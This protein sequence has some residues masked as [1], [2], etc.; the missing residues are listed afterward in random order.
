MRVSGIGWVMKRGEMVIGGT[1]E[2]VVM[3]EVS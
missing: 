3:V 2:V 1:G